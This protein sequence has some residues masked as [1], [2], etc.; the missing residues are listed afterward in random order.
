MKISP[1]TKIFQLL[2]AY[3]FLLDYLVSYNPEFKKLK[4]PILRNTLGRVATLE[5]AAKMAGVDL[6]KLMEDINTE[7][8]RQTGKRLEVYKPLS[9]EEK[10]KRRKI[11]EDI[12]KQLHA[13]APVAELKKRF[14][15]IIKDVDAT[16][17]A[18]MEQHLIENGFPQSE[19][20]RLCDLHAEIFRD[21]FES[22]EKVDVPAGHP[23]HTMR[24]ENRVLSSLLDDWNKLLSDS[25][26]R[27]GYWDEVSLLLNRISEMEKHY[28]RKENQLFPM[29]E[30]RGFTGPTQV[31]WGIHD[32][33]RALLKS[34]RSDIDS[35]NHGSLKEHGTEAARMMKEMIYKEENILFPTSLDLL[36]EEDW[37]RVRHGEEELGW[38]FSVKPTANWPSDD[39]A[40]Q[41]TSDSGKF[42]LD[43]GA[44]SVD[45]INLVFGHMPI[46]VSFVDH[47]DTV[48]FFSRGK[49]RIFP[50]SPGVIGRKVQ[51]CHP[52]KSLHMV[53]RILDAF[54]AGEKDKAEFWINFKER[55]IHINY[56]AVRD[57]KG[58]YRGT[59]ETVQDV[60]DIKNLKGERRLL[61][62]DED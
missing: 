34:L 47:E 29:L 46:E 16:E 28:L 7:I 56:F 40:V 42:E 26:E 61:D 37:I 23:V 2:D 53:Q 45:E 51:N 36:E 8:E 3:P 24:E 15:E 35:R 43:T 39:L 41:K 21:T 18:E 27:D 5:A 48:R 22:A 12:V 58:A 57:E 1:K 38:A 32:E 25:P 17:V 19:I 54:K 4:S 14:A 9:A 59:L 62:W 33:V 60:T 30:K 44:L 20:Q 52:P 13:G 6:Q 50:R 10:A 31:M 49:H 55:L 11:L